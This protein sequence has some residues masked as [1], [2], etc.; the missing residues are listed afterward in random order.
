MNLPGRF[1]FS[2]AAFITFLIFIVFVLFSALNW[3]IRCYDSCYPLRYDLMDINFSF[4]HTLAFLIGAWWSVTHS[5][6]CW[7][8][9]FFVVLFSTPLWVGNGIKWNTVPTLL[10]TS[11]L[12]QQNMLCILHPSCFVHFSN[13]LCT[14]QF[15][16]H[17]FL[18]LS[19]SF[20]LL[21]YPHLRPHNRW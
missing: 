14:V 1:W 7:S 4:N 17:I 5:D 19:L 12:A 15:C 21:C 6:Y 2:V 16:G 3:H 20:P 10:W 8:V 11:C 13:L 9:L 18:S